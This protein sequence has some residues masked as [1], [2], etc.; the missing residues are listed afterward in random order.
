[1][2][3][4]IE[5]VTINPKGRPMYA[6]PVEQARINDD[7]RQKPEPVIQVYPGVPPY[8]T[9]EFFEFAKKLNESLNR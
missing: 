1:M 2:P 4:K 8:G 5:I 6:E 7:R 3:T 9:P